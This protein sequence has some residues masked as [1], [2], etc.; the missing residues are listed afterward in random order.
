MPP[1]DCQDITKRRCLCVIPGSVLK[2]KL[3]IG[4]ERMPKERHEAV[5][6]KQ[7]RRGSLTRQ[8]RPLPLRLNASV[9]MTFLEGGFQTP[10]LHDIEDHLLSCL[11]VIG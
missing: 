9:G 10:P 1:H 6:A 5:Q 4:M 8:I 3:S 2:R 7:Q 11:A